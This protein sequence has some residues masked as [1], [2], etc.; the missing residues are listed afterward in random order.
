MGV[1]ISNFIRRLYH[2]C[3]GQLGTTMIPVATSKTILCNTFPITAKDWNAQKGLPCYDIEKALICIAAGS[4]W[5]ETNTGSLF[6]IE[7]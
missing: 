1:S 7:S 5:Y 6:G 2:G 4:G 3:V